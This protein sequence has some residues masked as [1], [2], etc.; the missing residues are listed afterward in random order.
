MTPIITKTVDVQNE[1][2]LQQKRRSQLLSSM[3]E[4]A[5]MSV[6]W[7][8]PRHVMVFSL[9]KMSVKPL[10]QMMCDSIDGKWPVETNFWLCQEFGEGLDKIIG[11]SCKFTACHPWLPPCQ[12][13]I[14]VQFG[15]CDFIFLLHQS[16]HSFLSKE[17]FG[18]IGVGRTVGD[19]QLLSSNNTC[20]TI[21]QSCLVKSI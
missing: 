7:I 20:S 10:I 8:F 14:F 13:F 21:E 19:N 11:L 16:I 18:K 2:F 6:E 12:S 5:M 15:E 1:C 3:K 9:E 4:Q 17:P